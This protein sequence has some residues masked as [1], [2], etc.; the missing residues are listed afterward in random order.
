MT[1]ERSP[2]EH[3]ILAPGHRI[4]AALVAAM[5]AAGLAPAAAE[6]VTLTAVRDNTLFQD[7]AGSL[8]NGAGP[9]MFAGR[10]NQNLTRRALIRFDVAASVPAGAVIS[11]AALALNVSNVSDPTPRLF[12][13]HR[14]QRDWG[15]STSAGTSGSG[16]PAASGDATWLHSFWPD[17]FWSI[18]G[19]DL[20]P[21]ASGSQFVGD[22]GH[23]S[24]SGSLLTSDVQAWLDSPTGNFGWVLLG[25]ETTS[26]T[27]RRFDSHEN[28]EVANRPTLT[29]TY[30]VSTG[31]SISSPGD[32]AALA[33]CHPNPGPG[34]VRFAFSIPITGHA[35]LIVS[36][37]TGR[38]V[39]TILD[40][41]LGPGSHEVGWEGLGP[42]GRSVSPG[43]YFYRLVLEGRIVAT[44][45]WIAL[46]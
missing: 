22:L 12:T 14:V 29:I 6:V 5:L 46:R 10:N 16:A 3:S 4:A 21:A 41:L 17:A 45:R 33:P 27:A 20:E 25:E 18:A 19:G 35:A 24:W 42:D 31:V 26:G 36:D 34:P 40:R 38:R 1:V 15:E 9:V 7:A 13:L 11:D 32:G 43:V 30:N 23:Y 2:G 37:V 8:S 39:A 28:A 44:R